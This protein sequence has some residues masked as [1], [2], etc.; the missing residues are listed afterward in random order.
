M[1]REPA[2]PAAARQ[3][4]TAGGAVEGNVFPYCIISQNKCRACMRVN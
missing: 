4:R 1:T 3:N 2:V